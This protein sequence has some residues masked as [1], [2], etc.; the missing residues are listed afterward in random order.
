LFPVDKAKLL[1]IGS[2]A[3]LGS[4]EYRKQLAAKQL[5]AGVPVDGPARPSLK[6]TAEE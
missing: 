6:L 5:A 3:E 1:A 4:A 2:D